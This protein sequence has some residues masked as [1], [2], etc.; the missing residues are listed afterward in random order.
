MEEGVCQTNRV[1]S[2]LASLGGRPAVW[3]AVLVLLLVA[4][5]ADVGRVF[6]ERWFGKSTFFH[7]IAVPPLVA[8]LV[9]SRWDRL[10]EVGARPS[11]WGIVALTG[12]LLLAV[13]GARLGVNLITG[14]SF[15]FVA[16]GLILLLLGWRALR[17]LAMPILVSFFAIAPPE[18]V[19]GHI[20]MPAQK[21]SALVTEH[22]AATALGLP[23]SRS[24][25]NLMLDGHTY[26]VAE[27]CSGMSSFLAMVLTVVVLIELS[28]LPAARK[29]LALLSIPVIVIC[30][31]VV[32]LC[33]VLLTAHYMG[34][35]FATG[36]LVHGG[37]D[38]IVYLT[39][40]VMVIMFL[41]AL[42]P[43]HHP[44]ETEQEDDETQE[45]QAE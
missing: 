41:G 5:Y 1:S 29:A 33:L 4:I 44:E 38:A 9:W 10:R 30:A 45:A 12:A 24:G 40:L 17:I 32:R 43:R 20:T 16:A 27:Q 21:V 3:V 8:W 19:L 14:V 7:C 39:A 11:P 34:N 13:L 6:I 2:R 31:N 23:V 42:S 22:V 28:G 26:A 37:T 35:E 18:H 36:H 15:P 25:I